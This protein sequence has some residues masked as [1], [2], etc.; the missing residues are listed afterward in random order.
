MG[1]PEGESTPRRR[2]VLRTPWLPVALAACGGCGPTWHFEYQDAE[3][4]A[5]AQERPLV[6][7]YKDPFDPKSSQMENLLD[8]EDIGEAERLIAREQLEALLQPD[9]PEED[10]VERWQKGGLRIRVFVSVFLNVHLGLCR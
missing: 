3:S 2:R 5:R 9:L 7:F 1:Q 8:K 10:Q 6:I 4:A